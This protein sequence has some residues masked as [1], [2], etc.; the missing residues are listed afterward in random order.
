MNEIDDEALSARLRLDLL[1]VL[2]HSTPLKVARVSPFTAL[3]DRLE[4]SVRE[5]ARWVN[6]Q[7]YLT[8]QEIS[9]DLWSGFC[10]VLRATP[11]TG[12]IGDDSLGALADELVAAFANCTRAVLDRGTK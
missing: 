12:A 9:D 7:E 8:D 1:Y 6:S 5:S 11:G 10:G 4:G 3:L 2:S